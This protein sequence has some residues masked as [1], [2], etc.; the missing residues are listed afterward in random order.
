MKWLLVWILLLCGFGIGIGVAAIVESLQEV[1]AMEYDSI[2]TF[3][4]VP[5]KVP[6]Y[7]LPMQYA[8]TVLRY[9]EEYDVPIWLACRLI[10]YESKWDANFTSARRRDGSRDEGLGAHNSRYK[11]D[12]DVY[13]S[14]WDS[15]RDSGIVGYNPFDPVQNI[16]VTV[17]LLAHLYLSARGFDV[18]GVDF[19]G[20]WNNA[21]SAYNLGLT[22]WRKTPRTKWPK[23]TKALVEYVMGGE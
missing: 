13:C 17:R 18:N 2:P 9:C 20:D 14:R 21:V 6:E 4:P 16:E 22:G 1:P 23:E 15:I 8:P 12:L 19:D 11:E 7:I 3:Q 10:T 5:R